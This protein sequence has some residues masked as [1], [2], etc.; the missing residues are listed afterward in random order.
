MCQ[1]VSLLTMFDRGTAKVLPYSLFNRVIRSRYSINQYCLMRAH[2]D[3]LQSK[4]ALTTQPNYSFL[5]SAVP[6]LRMSCIFNHP[7]IY[8]PTL[9]HAVSFSAFYEQYSQE[10][11]FQDVSVHCPGL[12]FF[13]LSRLIYPKICLCYHFQLSRIRIISSISSWR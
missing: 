3:C 13:S 5:N 2:L 1:F 9:A 11:I 4:S 12:P 10:K 6:P 7:N 8:T